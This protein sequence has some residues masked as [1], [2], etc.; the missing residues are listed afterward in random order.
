M[1][2]WI[3]GDSGDRRGP[4]SCRFLIRASCCHGRIGSV[5]KH[6][7][8]WPPKHR[9]G[10]RDGPVQAHACSVHVEVAGP[11]RGQEAVGVRIL[12]RAHPTTHG[13]GS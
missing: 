3:K 6:G 12:R 8:G 9:A 2:W 7:L 10:E 11:E 5:C 4:S 13:G 1:G